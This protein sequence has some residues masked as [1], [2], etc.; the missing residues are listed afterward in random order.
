MRTE[1]WVKFTCTYMCRI[2]VLFSLCTCLDWDKDGDV[3]AVTQDKNGMTFNTAHLCAYV[4]MYVYM[5]V[6]GCLIMEHNYCVTC[7]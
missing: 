5:H 2:F 3:L 7:A 1:V 4:Y 6:L